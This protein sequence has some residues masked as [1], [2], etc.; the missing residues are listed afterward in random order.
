MKAKALQPGDTIG[1][2]APA[3]KPRTSEKITKSVRYFEQLGYRVL[4]GKH[5]SNERGYLAGTD[6]ERLDDLHK[7]IGDNSV[8][9]IFDI[10]G[11]Y[12]SIRLLPYID[13]DLIRRNP[14]I[15]VGY[16]DATSM[17][18][19][20]YKK[21][22]L[23]SLFFGPMP[24]VDIWNG[25]DPFAEECMWKALTSN[26]PY[27]ALPAAKGEI[28]LFNNK[29]TDPVEGRILCGNLTVFSSI[30][31][32]P[33]I[34][35]LKDKVLFFE[36]ISEDIY[37]IDRYL[38]QLRAMGALDSAK[39]ILL[40]QFT[41]CNPQKDKPSLTLSQV[42]TDYFGKLSIPVLMN[43]PFGHIPRQWTVPL[44]AKMRVEGKSVS[45]I[46]SVLA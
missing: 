9:A 22:G 25:F 26:K 41:D 29:R 7:M 40:G 14:K 38:A 4:L 46:E 21:T 6:K 18:H 44:G 10:R 17:L 33:F 23:Q 28:K 43:L 36:D 37:R 31:A 11:G 45:I 12:G 24:G 13:Y 1:I 15:F 35:S 30:M 34:S 16:S 42:F 3:S 32:T 5:I 19:A 39:A 2:I 8:K 20:I 27:G